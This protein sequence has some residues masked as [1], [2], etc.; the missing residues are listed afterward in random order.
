LETQNEDNKPKTQHSNLKNR[1]EPRSWRQV[2]SSNL[3]EDTHHIAHR[4]AQ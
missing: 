3:L 2:S 4:Q 1:E